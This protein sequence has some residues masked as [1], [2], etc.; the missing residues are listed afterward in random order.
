MKN[1]Q[2]RTAR[3]LIACIAANCFANVPLW[4]LPEIL[5]DS[6]STLSLSAF[7]GSLVVSSENFMLALISI[8]LVSTD[9]R[10]SYRTLALAGTVVALIGNTLSAFSSDFHGFFLSRAVAGAGEGAVLMVSNALVANFRNPERAYAGMTIS[11][12]IYGSLA[13]FS[14]PLLF[15]HREGLAI[16]LI[17]V[18]ITVPLL[19][20]LFWLSSDRVQ[21]L[22]RHS[23]AVEPHMPAATFSATAFVLYGAMLLLGIGGGSCWAF[24]VEF[25]K[26]T[27]LS[28]ERIDL[29]IGVATIFAIAGSGAVAL[30]GGRYGRLIPVVIA[31]AAAGAASY[32]ISYTTSPVVFGID[33][34]A[35]L[36][37]NYF[38]F[39]YY[40]GFGAQIDRSGRVSSVVGAIIMLTSG[41]L[42]P[43]VGGYVSDKAGIASVGMVAFVLYAAA[44][45]LTVVFVRR[46]TRTQTETA[47]SGYRPASVPPYHHAGSTS[48]ARP[49]KGN[50]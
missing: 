6:I 20:L 10:F 50:P 8:L 15:S 3:L 30:L 43:L 33:T 23:D 37:F 21:R 11:N 49:N 9:F 19:P 5:S 16:F 41:C 29:A 1:E 46:I 36:F 22:P 40:L 13:F 34:A 47:D 42:G 44:I 2:G 32:S 39:P 12:V 24:L 14:L 35:L 48:A 26:Q 27:S 28:Q 25:G 38:L 17:I 4:L 31:A 45:V 7:Q 18:A